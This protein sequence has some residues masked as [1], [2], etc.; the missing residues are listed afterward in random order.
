M[1]GHSVLAPSGAECW[2]S[3]TA[4]AAM[5]RDLP[6]SP[7]EYSDEGTAAHL[8]LETCLREE[9]TP[10]AFAGMKIL[11]GSHPE[12]NWDGAVWAGVPAADIDPCFELRREYIVDEEM[13]E[14]IGRAVELI[15]RYAGDA[16]LLLEAEHKVAVGKYT[17]EPDG[18]GTMD[19]CVVVPG[20][21]QVHDLKYGKGVEVE[22]AWNKQLALYAVGKLDELDEL[23]YGPIKRVRFVIHQ[24]RVRTKPA[25]WDCSVEE[26]RQFVAGAITV[27]GQRAWRIYQHPEEMSGED[28]QPG[29]ETCRWCKAKPCP[30][31]LQRAASEFAVDF[32]AA[33]PEEFQLTTRDPATIGRMMQW[34][35]VLEQIGKAVRAEC[36]RMLFSNIEVPDW[37]LVEGKRGNR[38]WRDEEEAD[39][40]M[41]SMRLT[42][43]ERCNLKLKSPAQIEKVLKDSPRKL[44]RLEALVTQKEGQP[45]VAPASDKRPRWTPPN[46]ADQFTATAE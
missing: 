25:E 3:C 36:E 14:A 42:V 15:G 45:S 39:Q 10:Q 11:V 33:P 41:R 17:T 38:Q 19:C 30:A 44:K 6:D 31:M 32:Q 5:Q 12:S 2:T 23:L 1:S 28:F 18:R 22:A 24:P 4:S 43:E 16:P 7:S 35:P 29:A 46:P 26:L 34:V 27:K 20:E 9:C 40:A 8:L 37:K 21:L 13:V